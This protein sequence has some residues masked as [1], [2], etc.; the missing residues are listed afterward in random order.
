M[1]NMEVN[2]QTREAEFPWHQSIDLGDG[3]VTPG[4]KSLEVC[5][6]EACLIF[7]RIDLSGRTVLDI[8]AWNGAFSFEAKRRGAARV[9]ATDSYYCSHPLSRGRETFE[10][11][12][13]AL[14]AEVD[15]RE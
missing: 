5:N 14:G 2:L 10:I 9:L 15:A 12:R 1:P 13:S 3:V 8:G 6:A 4:G 11:A 7:D